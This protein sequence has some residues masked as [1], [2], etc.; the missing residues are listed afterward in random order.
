MTKFPLVVSPEVLEGPNHLNL[1]P[2]LAFERSA[3]PERSGRIEPLERLERDQ[4]SLAVERLERVFFPTSLTSVAFAS[5]HLQPINLG[6]FP[7][8]RVI[9]AAFGGV[10][11]W[12]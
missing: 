6:N 4:Y 12:F 1:E 10:P 2:P 5:R 9:F 3:C 7:L 11:G 8:V